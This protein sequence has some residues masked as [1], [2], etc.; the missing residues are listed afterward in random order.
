MANLELIGGLCFKKDC[1]PGQEIIVRTQYLGT[2]KRAPCLTKIHR[3][4]IHRL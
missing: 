1:Y 3:Q 4:R 2:L